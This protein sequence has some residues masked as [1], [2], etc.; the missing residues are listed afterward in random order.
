MK[1]WSTNNPKA[2]LMMKKRKLIIDAAFQEFLGSGYSQTSMDRIATVAG[3][4]VKTVYR[5]FEN[6]DDLFSTVMNAACSRNGLEQLDV[7]LQRN[8]ELQDKLWFNEPPQDA[9]AMAGTEYLQHVLSRDQLALY[10]VV[11]QDAHRFPELGRR[12]RKEVIENNIILFTDYLKKWAYSENWNIRNHHN[13]ASIFNALLRTNLFEDAL[14]GI[15]M[16]DKSEIEI[17]A[18]SAADS[19]L[20]LL[21]AGI[22]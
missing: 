14:H 17:Q 11:T 6:K 13:A 19:M 16:P 7:D 5:H 9:L 10:R 1:S 12:Y 3:V 2:S 15:H 20:I 18:R 21:K 22:L 4:S 8:E